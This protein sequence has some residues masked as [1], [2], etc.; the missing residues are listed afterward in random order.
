MIIVDEGPL[1]PTAP[2]PEF[3]NAQGLILDPNPDTML[4]ELAC[5]E[6]DLI[7][8]EAHRRPGPWCL[9]THVTNLDDFTS[10]WP[11]AVSLTTAFAMSRSSS[12]VINSIT[13]RVTADDR[14]F[15]ERCVLKHRGTR[16]NLPSSWSEFPLRPASSQ[17]SAPDVCHPDHHYPVPGC[18][19]CFGHRLRSS[20]PN[21]G[22]CLRLRKSTVEDHGCC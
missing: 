12:A 13:Y 2:L 6:V 3:E 19:R 10:S 16:R 15:T 20:T 1:W 11:I 18:Y 4:E 14:T 7:C 9:G 5:F 22:P 21:P 17:N 8:V